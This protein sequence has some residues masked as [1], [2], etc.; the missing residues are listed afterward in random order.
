MLKDYKNKRIHVLSFTVCPC[1]ILSLYWSYST[2]ILPRK[3]SVTLIFPNRN[4]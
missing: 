4:R 3:P 2:T 1:G